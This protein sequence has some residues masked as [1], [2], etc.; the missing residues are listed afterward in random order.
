[1]AS[2]PGTIL[3]VPAVPVPTASTASSL[4]EVPKPPGVTQQP[5]LNGIRIMRMLQLQKKGPGARE[6]S[7]SRQPSD[8]APSRSS[9]FSLSAAR[10]HPT[11]DVP[12]K[13]ALPR[14]V[15]PDLAR[16]QP[17]VEE[18]GG[19]SEDDVVPIIQRRPRGRPRKDRSVVVAP[20][21]P[22]SPSPSQNGA[23]EREIAAA[24]I[25][26]DD[27]ASVSGALVVHR[28]LLTT[29]LDVRY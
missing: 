15:P 2:L 16:S 6:V 24:S 19:D 25:L 13:L 14:R 26:E 11:N 22:V 23:S 28:A 4:A 1:M 17:R 12:P 7:G 5:S 10:Q 9:S 27:D 3:A 8:E 29:M 21:P 18:P 20:A